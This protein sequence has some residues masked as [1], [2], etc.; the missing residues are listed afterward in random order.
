MVIVWCR[1][2]WK[3]FKLVVRGCH[4]TPWDLW[5]VYQ[6]MF[7]YENRV[8]NK[9]HYYGGKAHGNLIGIHISLQA[10]SKDYD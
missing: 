3:Q 4:Q 8:N 10:I 9:D 5:Q 1:R 2:S 6:P 7:G